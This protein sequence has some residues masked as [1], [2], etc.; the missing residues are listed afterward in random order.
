MFD[1][2][3]WGT[4]RNSSSERQGIVV[5]DEADIYGPAGE[6]KPEYAVRVQVCYNIFDFEAIHLQ[7]YITKYHISNF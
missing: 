3:S 1:R 6:C 5:E 7:S 2:L 4:Y